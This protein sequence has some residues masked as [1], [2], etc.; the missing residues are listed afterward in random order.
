MGEGARRRQSTLPVARGN[1]VIS[2]EVSTG[3]TLREL[4]AE[5]GGMDY[6]AVGAAVRSFSP[7]LKK[8]T[9]CKA[10]YRRVIE[11]LHL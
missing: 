7:R 3:M 10:E 9:E 5:A 11:I 2:K 8:N 6:A 1:G 4:G